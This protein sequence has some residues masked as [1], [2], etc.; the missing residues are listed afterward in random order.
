VT[1]VRKRRRALLGRGFAATLLAAALLLPGREA[2]R[3]VAVLT[4]IAETGRA[5]ATADRIAATAAERGVAVSRREAS[6]TGIDDAL[7]SSL[8]SLAPGDRNAVV[9][10]SHGRW[11]REAAV[12][13]R[14]AAAAGIPVFWQ[15]ADGAEAPELLGLRTLERAAPGERI[16]VDVW[17][18]APPDSALDII[19]YAGGDPLVRGTAAGVAPTRLDVEFARAGMRPLDA[20][21]VDRSSGAVVDRLE[22]AA[23]INVVGPPALLVVSRDRSP[24][25]DALVAGG[26]PVTR[27]HPGALAATAG[28][29]G[30]YGAVILD[31]IPA[32][33][34][35][36]PAWD[37]IVTA[38]RNGETG[39][40]VL[41]GPA[42]FGLGAYRDS[43][44]ER[45]LPVISEPPESENPVDM[46]FLADVS[47]SMGRR[48]YG[49]LR[50][51]RDAI[52]ET[53]RALRP[54]DR[55]GLVSFDVQ[56]RVLLPPATRDDHA[57]ALRAAFPEHASGG[58]RVAPAI[59]S[60]LALFDEAGER[61]RL[62]VLVTDGMLADD[63]IIN[64]ET[65]LGTGG[66]DLIA[67]VIGT[68]ASSAP[69][70]RIESGGP[71]TVL[72]SHDLAG[73][74]GLMRDEVE[75]RRPALARG[76]ATP[77][78]IR[79]G[80]LPGVADGAWPV[81]DGWLVTRPRSDATVWLAAPQ[82]EPL[83]AVA[84]AG[85]GRVAALTGGLDQWAGAWLEWQHWPEFAAG[86][87]QAVI[88]G[89][90]EA[91]AVRY[92]DETGAVIIDSATDDAARRVTVTTPDGPAVVEAQAL[93]P[94]RWRVSLPD[95]APGIWQLTWEDDETRWRHA[96]VHGRSRVV[97]PQGLV[98]E[99]LI[100]D[101]VMRRWGADSLAVLAAPL[102]LGRWLAVA[103]LLTFLATLALERYAGPFGRT[104]VSLDRR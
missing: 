88:I 38:V 8:R 87:V 39:L 6:G 10:V 1:D 37:A 79:P 51:A 5:A 65:T 46:V 44:L 34:V 49:A 50:A 98:A 7:E 80:F 48:D 83:L 60:G 101:G 25:A 97:D 41:G 17:H 32:D 81:L 33:A 56:A 29:S 78:V 24:L 89:S 100:D 73:L 91:A 84:T 68:A 72:V 104:G 22:D 66:V 71:V 3:G 18:T 36:E 70:E 30:R 92:Q 54:S 103:A 4:V 20:E 53:A 67:I 102:P 62:L 45:I 74:P 47:G 58:T 26:W 90:T 19:V 35:P 55:T 85:A 43:T 77:V 28:D 75:S 99:T 93:A 23:V 86:L 14:Q 61:Q 40:L 96:F 69:L 42:S 27:I 2:D 9:L 16:G 82:G 59:E 31:D 52:V 64:L 12:L 76:P 21:L 94:G 63:E 13:A 57:A 15:P 11:P 95:G